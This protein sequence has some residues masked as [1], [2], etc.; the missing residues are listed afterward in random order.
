MND[1][2]LNQTQLAARCTNAAQDLFPDDQQTV[3]TRERIARIL[4][5]CKA[6]PGKSAAR[7]ITAQEMFVLSK[8][9]KVSQ[10][11]LGGQGASRDIVL[12]DPLADPARAEQILH[13]MNEY[14]DHAKE[15]LVWAEFLI[16]S[17]ETPEFMHRH[18]EALFAELDLIAPEQ[19]RKAVQVFDGIGNARRKR[20]FDSGLRRKLTQIIFASDLRRISRG[21]GEY[22]AI[23]KD[24]RRACLEKLCDLISDQSLAFE[25]VIA[26]DDDCIA[27][28]AA[29]RDYDSVGVY[30]DRM[31]MWRY[32]SGMFAWSEHRVHTLRYRTALQD[33]VS[34][35]SSL[36]GADGVRFIKRLA[37]SGR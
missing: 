21:T 8:V 34:R 33:L 23:G 7:A 14:E 12:W 20:F 5:H 1:L 31:V 37:R 16:C 10:E 22:A 3:I 2:A 35:P 19:K 36:R 24:L 17:L 27:A 4:M 9:L 18:H 11:W 15:L 30:D 28:R 6:S 25:L 13:L 29:L 26:D 32:H